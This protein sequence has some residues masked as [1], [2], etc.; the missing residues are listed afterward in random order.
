MQK[1]E[2]WLPE[3]CWS[4]KTDVLKDNITADRQSFISLL[5][6]EYPCVVFLRAWNQWG[7]GSGLT[8]AA[9]KNVLPPTSI[10]RRMCANICA[11]FKACTRCRW[12][13]SMP[14]RTPKPRS[15]GASSW[16]LSRRRS[17]N[18]RIWCDGCQRLNE[19]FCWLC[20]ANKQLEFSLLCRLVQVQA[21]S[22]E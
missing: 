18:V 3:V 7:L 22:S 21:R 2:K 5:Y 13:T 10:T 16:S 12:R 4:A 6:Q 20:T 19:K 11:V 17:G 15:H 14:E 9:K 8:K 1:K